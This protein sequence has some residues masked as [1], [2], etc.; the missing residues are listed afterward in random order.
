MTL[1]LKEFVK[2]K[3]KKKKKQA[4]KTKGRAVKSFCFA[5]NLR[6]LISQFLLFP[7]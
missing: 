7:Y 2:Y 6:H 1:V 4:K 3:I 5:I